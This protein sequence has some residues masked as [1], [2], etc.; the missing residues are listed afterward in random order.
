MT[1]PKVLL[2]DDDPRILDVIRLRLEAEGYEVILA[3]TGHDALRLALR[4]SPDVL[5]L[6]INLPDANGLTV[7]DRLHAH[8]GPWPPV[9]YLT[10][11]RSLRT[12]L[13]VKMLG[14][15]A[16]IYKPFDINVLLETVG[17]ACRRA[18]RAG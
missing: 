5:I 13:H 11:D 2:A 9:I 1:K 18:S 10:G 4:H 15:F 3:A 14:G 7:H 8:A 6:D 12:E 16:V 17:R